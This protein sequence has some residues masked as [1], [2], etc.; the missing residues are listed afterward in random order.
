MENELVLHFPR[1]VAS[2]W[3]LD[4]PIPA[5]L[6]KCGKAYRHKSVNT[7]LR[8]SCSWTRLLTTHC[9][10]LIGC[11][12]CHFCGLHTGILNA[13]RPYLTQTFT[14]MSAR[15]VGA[16]FPALAFIPTRVKQGI[17]SFR[18]WRA[19]SFRLCGLLRANGHH[20]PLNQKRWV[21][22]LKKKKKEEEEK[23]ERAV[24]V[25]SLWVW[26]PWAL[27]GAGAKCS[28]LGCAS[29]W[30]LHVSVLAFH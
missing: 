13:Q 2:L 30:H 26:T 8:G 6:R 22:K 11:G 4:M 19:W 23:E 5:G 14:P 3:S 16:G 25:I 29:D 7:N 24:G 20:L 15:W 17:R 9:C 18:C 12:F 28:S 27:W 21:G 1:A 10:L